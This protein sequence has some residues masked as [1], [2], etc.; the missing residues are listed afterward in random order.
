M[1][2][3]SRFSDCEGGRFVISLGAMAVVLARELRF[4]RSGS[5]VAGS[6][7]LESRCAKE[8][9]RFS[10]PPSCEVSEMVV[11]TVEAETCLLPAPRAV[12][13]PKKELRPLVGELRPGLV[14]PWRPGEGPLYMLVTTLAAG[15]SELPRL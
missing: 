7:D 14:G 6:E 1:D 8:A 9:S 13:A 4:V 15:H 11:G 10:F 3:T 5:D 2:D 12:A